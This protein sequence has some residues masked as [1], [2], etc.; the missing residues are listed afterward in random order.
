MKNYSGILGLLLLTFGFSCYVFPVYAIPCNP[1]LPGSGLS[2]STACLDGA[3]GDDTL[4]I[5]GDYAFDINAGSYFGFNDWQFLQL[6]G[7]FTEQTEVDVGLGVNGI[8]MGFWSISATAG[9]DYDNLL[10]ILKSNI[11]SEDMIFWSSYLLSNTANMGFWFSGKPLESFSVFGRVS[12]PVPEAGT[13]SLM[14]AGLW[15]MLLRA[16]RVR[17]PPAPAL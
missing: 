8:V 17:R 15:V 5:V 13:F 2:G 4:G 10:V 3:P 6:K 11:S 7:P 1:R 9:M 12:V 16:G 14:L